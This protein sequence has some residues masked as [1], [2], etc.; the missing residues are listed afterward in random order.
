[1]GET[2]HEAIAHLR[3]GDRD[4]AHAIVRRDLSPL[5]CRAHGIVHLQEGDVGNAQYGYGRAGRT[6][7][8]D[9]DPRA[10][11]EAL[12]RAWEDRPR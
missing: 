6:L 3:R 2:L 1:M 12:A 8:R 10:G 7:A 4:L 11:I 5:S 9:G